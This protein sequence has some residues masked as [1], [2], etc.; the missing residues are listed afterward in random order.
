MHVFV[1]LPRISEIVIIVLNMLSEIS[2]TEKDKT[3]G[4]LSKGVVP[5]DSGFGR[6]ILAARGENKGAMPHGSK[7]ISLEAIVRDN[8]GLDKGGNGR[9][10]ER[11]VGI[12]RERC[13]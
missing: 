8:S 11:R 1:Y 4:V 10:G 7:E 13:W 3:T 6:T 12:P 9:G 2:Q 5:S